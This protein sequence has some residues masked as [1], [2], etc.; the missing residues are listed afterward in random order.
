MKVKAIDDEF[1]YRM[2]G[3]ITGR[4]RSRRVEGK[5]RSEEEG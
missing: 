3:I 4:R 1:E 2:R 5:Q